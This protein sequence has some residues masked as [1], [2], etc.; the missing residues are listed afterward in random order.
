MAVSSIK[1]FWIHPNALTITLNYFGDPQLIQ[2]SMLAGS[3]IMAYRKDVITYDA[4]HNFREWRLQAFPTQLNDTCAYYV[5]AELSRSGDTAMIIY[6]PV[7]RDIEG[8]TLL[9]VEKDDNGRD[10]EVWD[11]NLSTESYF[12]YLGTISASVDNDGATVE[13]AWIDGFY[14]GTLDTDQQRME[15]VAGEWKT[16]FNYNA[17]IDQIEPLKPFSKIKVIGEAI[18]QSIA[19]FVNGIVIGKR[20]ITDV[21]ASSDSGNES[22]VSDA[23][24][25]TT[26]YVQKEIEALDDHFLIKDGG[27]PQEVGGDVS[28][29][30]NVSVGGGHSVGGDQT[31]EGNQEVKGLQT[32]HEGFTTEGFIDAA[33][34]IA[35]AQLTRAGIFTAAGVKTMSLEVFELYYNVIRAQGNTIV[36]SSAANIDAVKYRVL[37]DDGYPL[38]VSPEL[39]YESYSH[40]PILSVQLL[41]RKD[42]TNGNMIPFRRGD[43]LYGYVNKI[44]NS[45]QYARSGQCIMEVTSTD[46]QIDQAN[47]TGALLISAELFAVGT[48]SPSNPNVVS[49]NIPPTSGMSIAQRGNTLGTD[50]RT[51]CFFID[52]LEGRLYML[53][54][55]THPNL[56]KENYYVLLGKMP[57]D[58][59]ALVQ[60]SFSY[61]G[62]DDPVVYARYGI[63]ENFLHLDHLGKPIPSSRYRG[64]WSEKVASGEVP[65]EDKYT[66]TN[67]IYDTVTYDGSLWKCMITGT[68]DIPSEYSKGWSLLISKG[69]SFRENLL[70]NTSQFNLNW[71]LYDKTQITDGFSGHK[72]LYRS[73]RSAGDIAYQYITGS[74][75]VGSDKVSPN[76]WYTL[77][78]YVKGYTAV[79]VN[80][81][82]MNEDGVVTGG[83]VNEDNSIVVDGVYTS[84]SSTVVFD[85]G[86][87]DGWTRHT[88]S[89][90]AAETV[91]SNAVI[92]FL[93]PKGS[94]TITIST[95]KLELGKEATQWTANANDL[96][97]SIVSELVRYA[98]SDNGTTIPE[99]E[100]NWSENFPQ[101]VYGKYIWTWTKVTYSTGQET[102]AYSVSRVGIDG[103]GIKSSEVDY[104]QQP[105]PVAPESIANWGAFP[106][107]LKDGFW[108]YTRTLITYYNSD[109][110]D[111]EQTA[112]YS[113]SQI[114]VGSY[115][116]GLEEWYAIHND[117]NEPPT[118]F[119]SKGQY[120]A[121]A[122]LN[123]T[124]EDWK[125]ERLRT[126]TE[127]PYLWNFSISRD[128]RGNAYVT[129]VICIGNFAKGIVSIVESYAISAYSTP[130]AGGYYPSD[131]KVWVDEHQDAAPTEEKPYQWN[132]TET[133]YNDE[134]VE[135]IYHV[136]AVKGDRG[137]GIKN[138]IYEYLVT[139][140]GTQPELSDSG[141][142]PDRPDVKAGEYL[143]T[144]TI[145]DYTDGTQND[146]VNVTV[147]RVSVD[148]TSVT[149]TGTHYAESESGTDIPDDNDWGE[150][151]PSVAEGN[152]LWT[153]IT[154]SDDNKA[155]S[156]SKDGESLTITSIKYSTEFTEKQPE[157]DTFD[158]EVP[159]SGTKGG[160]VWSLTIYSDGTRDY[161]K[162]Y[163]PLDGNNGNDAPA[164]NPN[165]LLNTNFDVVEG[166]N[167]SAWYVYP[168][169]TKLIS[170]DR[171][172]INGYGFLNSITCNTSGHIISQDLNFTFKKGDIITISCV[173]KS[174]STE[175]RGIGIL[176]RLPNADG[177]YDGD[178]WKASWEWSGMEGLIDTAI[179]WHD[180]DKS[181]ARID[182]PFRTSSDWRERRLTLQYKGEEDFNQAIIHF[183]S[184]NP[185]YGEI[186]QIK[187]ERGAVVTP[188]L[189]AQDD[190][191]GLGIKSVSTEY[192]VTD[193]FVQPKVDSNEWNRKF[194]ESIPDGSYLWI[195]TVT[196]YTDKS[197]T[198]T[199]SVS[200]VGSE[201]TSVTVTE[202][203][204]AVNKS[205]T[206]YPSS[207]WKTATEEGKLP[208][209]AGEG[210]Y[211]W[212][213]VTFSDDTKE[214]TTSY[215]GK[216]LTIDSIMY[217]VSD[218]NE[219][220]EDDKFIYATPPKPEKKKYIW[221]KTVYSDENVDYASA[222]IPDDGVGVSN[223]FMKYAVTDTYEVPTSWL[224]KRP[225]VAEGQ[226]L[227]T[228]T[229]VDYTDSK[230]GDEVGI[231]VSRVG[232]N[233][234]SITVVGTDYAISKDGVDYPTDENVWAEKPSKALEED[235]YL[236]TRTKFSEGPPMYTVSRNGDS[237]KIDTIRYSNPTTESSN[238]EKL[239]YNNTT[240]PSAVKGKYIWT[241][242]VYSDKS[243]EY[244]S[245]YT[246]EDGNDAGN[247]YTLLATP[248]TIYVNK[249]GEVSSETISLSVIETTPYGTTAIS[250]DR[251]QELGLSVQYLLADREEE[252]QP[253]D[254]GNMFQTDAQFTTVNFF[255]VHNGE[256]ISTK[257]V[258]FPREGKD[259]NPPVSYFAE[260]A[261]VNVQIDAQTQEIINNRTENVGVYARTPY[262]LL[263][264]EDY[265]IS[266]PEVPDGSKVTFGEPKYLND[267]YYF[268]VSFADGAKRSEIITS[269][270][271]K[272]HEADDDSIMGE[273]PIT[274]AISERG[275]AGGQGASG[276]ML[277]PCGR[278]ELGVDYVGLV[279]L[280]DEKPAALPI[281]YYQTTE[282][283]EGTYYVLQKD[284]YAKDNTKE[285]LKNT[286][287]W[288]PFEKYKYIATEFLMANWAK[289]GSE[290]GAV[291][292]DR[293]L[294]SQKCVDGDGNS[295]DITDPYTQRDMFDSLGNLT[296]DAVPNMI[297]DF[298]NGLSAVSNSIET[299]RRKSGSTIH[300]TPETGYNI[301]ITPNIPPIGVDSV[302][303]FFANNS[304]VILPSIDEM[305]LPEWQINGAHITITFET[306]GRP[307][308]HTIAKQTSESM[309]SRNVFLLVCV[310]D[311]CLKEFK[312]EGEARDI[313]AT[314]LHA[315]PL[316]Y[317]YDNFIFNRGIRGK[318]VIMAPGNTLRLRPYIWKDNV[319]KSHIH[320]MVDSPNVT[321][322]G[323]TIYHTA[324]YLPSYAYKPNNGV[325]EVYF[326]NKKSDSPYERE[327]SLTNNGGYWDQYRVYASK[328]E[329]LGSGDYTE[330]IFYNLYPDQ[331]SVPESHR[332]VCFACG[333]INLLPD[334]IV[335]NGFRIENDSES[336]IKGDYRCRAFNSE[337]DHDGIK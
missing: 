177:K 243:V 95:P 238:P 211:L 241:K 105:S 127:K 321:E 114:G 137:R 143:W 108:L 34:H 53:D 312:I 205:P 289:F 302:P 329:L 38:D 276:P 233:G 273:Q 222:Y 269:F 21:A 299:Y 256:D 323:L 171:V 80:I 6:S 180:E 91:S 183:Y 191:M 336:I 142:S 135:T 294:F 140:T 206:N 147:S 59:F 47:S 3:V 216:S 58:L 314:N 270:S 12:I 70:N 17:V 334:A 296:G 328:T 125:Q 319:D 148:G 259:G 98:T 229:V 195:K 138:I 76:E 257:T 77:S 268:S 332:G 48:P 305:G 128:S 67:A 224:D 55:V 10:V 176:I 90:L 149:T 331:E 192:A 227:W 202:V 309:L 255:L 110:T 133:T 174:D 145:T 297:F 83:V 275:W 13:R 265:Y 72:G 37:T 22:I 5:H 285:N 117:G 56:F 178:A 245:T 96:S 73:N 188:Y 293:Y 274:I 62:E 210:E 335:I 242:I 8:R 163:V 277:Y 190:L 29:R 103:K 14:T 161:S 313:Y 194:P 35:G 310:D 303:S 78:F 172:V 189:K 156:V 41:I 200:K 266:L 290:N 68:T 292:Y 144:K 130:N 159:P 36:L 198:V 217:A 123:P 187:V 153:R 94:S 25:P 16:I 109:G 300:I 252:R 42:P 23:T 239:A 220:P 43:I 288:E 102:N 93:A 11:N 267:K 253:F 86:S 150:T 218:T 168:D 154:F 232:A 157:D 337:Y 214:Y 237:L 64:V 160:Y 185:S 281:M 119:I 74:Q 322:M 235:E 82:V 87:E 272:F 317:E 264:E 126:T 236:W 199:I 100:G 60:E 63:F 278:L 18:F 20:T 186:S 115:Y 179:G 129:D 260:P 231:T 40:N 52:A 151:I 101:N 283:A 4:A 57:S 166:N 291:F 254:I 104:S 308:G 44:G 261:I 181:T 136:S 134:S 9:R 311:S 221:T 155:Y 306:G 250:K 69:N 203:A 1:D 81:G 271:V 88:I 287:Y 30:G 279:K 225:T 304:I 71:T 175:A 92:L 85:V 66:A 201:G 184:W 121:D 204:Y 106:D 141:W 315:A 7:K 79:S 234:D 167:L 97:S 49:S 258:S 247:T 251:L 170:K 209:A 132:K 50:G 330:D 65:T 61:V 324:Y 230:K 333:L 326:H 208:V 39:Y 307:Y 124:T 107:E 131:I 173:A 162:S 24:L 193:T 215:N 246:P 120:G 118:G 197:D 301:S 226:Y 262:G 33:G 169:K 196:D 75:S 213:R 223:I 27:D 89:F 26:G 158:L 318:Y 320:W 116:A 207:G 280:K 263:T 152:Y 282:N 112:S 51:S 84:G 32:L 298:K 15:D 19:Q 248:D 111:G 46:E 182:V 295:V 54:N 165:I 146:E 219:Q 28:F 99:P 228:K 113:V 249:E 286:E 316:G 45:G 31:I 327:T 139:T 244:Y 212:T 2:T 122:E 284:I 164:T 325:N 240:I